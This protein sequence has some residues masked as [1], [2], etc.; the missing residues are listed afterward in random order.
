MPSIDTYKYRSKSYFKQVAL[1]NEALNY[2]EQDIEKIKCPFKRQ[3]I[4]K[5]RE[6]IELRK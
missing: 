3:E 6:E 1:E 2:K 4:Q 5:L